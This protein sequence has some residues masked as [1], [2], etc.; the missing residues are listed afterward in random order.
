MIYLCNPAVRP[1]HKAPAPSS[2][3]TVLVVPIRPLYFMLSAGLTLS[4]LALAVKAKAKT[5]PA[6]D[7]G[8]IGE[9]Y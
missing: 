1:F 9:N 4:L 8:L 5:V 7:P 3:M 6:V 2:E